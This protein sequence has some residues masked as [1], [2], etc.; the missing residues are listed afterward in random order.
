MKKVRIAN[1]VWKII[2]DKKVNAASFKFDTNE[3]R[4]DPESTSAG[5]SLLHEIVEITAT[6]LHTRYNT[7]DYQDPTMFIMT[8][9]QLDVLVNT[10]YGDLV[11]MGVLDEKKI[12]MLVKP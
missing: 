8:H 7:Y 1:E 12:R 11:Q 4:V 2:P 5:E 9:G 10:L 3:I 6:V